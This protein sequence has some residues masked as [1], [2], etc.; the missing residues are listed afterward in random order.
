LAR[1]VRSTV[2]VKYTEGLSTSMDLTQAENQLTQAQADYINRLF[3]ALD[4]KLELSR[5]FE[6]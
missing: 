2:L 5:V 4:A 3:S 6:E 1:S